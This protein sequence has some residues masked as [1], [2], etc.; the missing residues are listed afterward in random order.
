[1]E[2][3]LRLLRQAK[4]GDRQAFNDLYARYWERLHTV[5][6]FRLG[7]ALRAKLE[8]ADIVQEALL[9]SLRGIERFEYRSDGDFLHWLCKLVENRIRDQ[10]DYFHAEKRLIRRETPLQTQLPT[11]ST[12]WGPLNLAGISKTPSID[13]VRHEELESL[14]RA[15]DQLPTD[16]REAVILTRYEGLRFSEAGAMLDKS[17]DA[18]RMLV[19]RALVRL[20]KELR[21]SLGE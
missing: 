7:P 11:R 6:R 4:E 5:V 9:V 14:E 12:V 18:I 20:A 17:P 15:V 16:Q 21:S 1:M 3:T 10:V 13:A 8:S 2:T 19:S